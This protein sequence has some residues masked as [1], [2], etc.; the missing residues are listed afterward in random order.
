MCTSGTGNFAWFN[1]FEAEGCVNALAILAAIGLVGESRNYTESPRLVRE[2]SNV[3]NKAIAFNGSLYFEADTI[4]RHIHDFLRLSLSLPPDMK[5]D[6]PN[7]TFVE[8]FRDF[9]CNLEF[10]FG[11]SRQYQS[12]SAI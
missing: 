4:S 1:G 8:I 10:D 11:V 2:H 7:D 3:A 9:Y 6:G 5:A 12:A